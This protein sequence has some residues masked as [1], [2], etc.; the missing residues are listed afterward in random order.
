[1]PVAPKSEPK[2]RTDHS[3]V[4][5]LDP[6]SSDMETHLSKVK[7]VVAVASFLCVGL[8]PHGPATGDELPSTSHAMESKAKGSPARSDIWPPH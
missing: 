5:P 8:L 6:L 2:A 1:M 3:V 7:I 4:C